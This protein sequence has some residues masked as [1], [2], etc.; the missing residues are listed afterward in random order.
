M[1]QYPYLI[2]ISKSILHILLHFSQGPTEI[3]M[4]LKTPSLEKKCAKLTEK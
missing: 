1:F 2:Y 3:K 4:T